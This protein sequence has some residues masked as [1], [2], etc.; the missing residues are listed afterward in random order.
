MAKALKDPIKPEKEELEAA[1]RAQVETIFDRCSELCGFS[2]G[3]RLV[4]ENGKEGVREWELYV[5]AVAAYPELGEGQAED[6]IGEISDVLADLLNQ[7][8]QAADLLPGRTFAR[9]WH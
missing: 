7:R 9:V 6:F 1:L 3:E 2:V 4:S 8:P 5:S